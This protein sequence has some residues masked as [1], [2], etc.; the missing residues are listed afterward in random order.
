MNTEAH[1]KNKA[2][3][4]EREWQAQ[5]RAL[6]RERRGLAAAD[7]EARVRRYRVLA[8]ALREPPPETLPADFAR[9][10]AAQA[11]AIAAAKDEVTPRFERRLMQALVA[12]FGLSVGAVIALYG[13]DWL[14]QT[15]EIT[16]AMHKLTDRWLL[17]LLGC[18]GLS[19]LARRVEAGLRRNA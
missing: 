18:V 11:E 3:A 2:E 9:R 17:A 5:E 8:R 12:A 4:I 14:P 15:A 16:A 10:V 1:P 6:E 7:D 19:V 13:T